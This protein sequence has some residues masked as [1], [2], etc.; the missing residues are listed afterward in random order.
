MD[1]DCVHLGDVEDGCVLIIP[2]LSR[3]GVED[4]TIHRRSHE[5]WWDGTGCRSYIQRGVGP[6]FAYVLRPV[7]V[8]YF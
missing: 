7:K 2:E 5:L 8:H 3:P 6:I 1:R 4:E